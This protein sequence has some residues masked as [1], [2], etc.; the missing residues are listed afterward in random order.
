MEFSSQVIQSRLELESKRNKA[1]SV[2][3]ALLQGTEAGT[4]NARNFTN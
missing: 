4:G 3:F 2:A 1:V